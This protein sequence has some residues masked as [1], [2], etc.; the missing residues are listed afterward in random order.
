MF[1][2]SAPRLHLHEIILCLLKMFYYACYVA[3]MTDFFVLYNNYEY[4]EI[5]IQFGDVMEPRLTDLTERVSNNI[6]TTSA[7]SSRRWCP[8]LP[9]AVFVCF[10]HFIST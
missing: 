2:L 4:L 10:G 6:L 9:F 7:H 1:V 3:F 5:I 8:N